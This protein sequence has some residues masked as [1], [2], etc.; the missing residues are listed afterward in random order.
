MVAE[1]GGVG[2]DVSDATSQ[3][4]DDVETIASTSTSLTQL[5]EQQKNLV[6]QINAWRELDF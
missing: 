4:S 6:E 3:K 1:E 5:I 2:V